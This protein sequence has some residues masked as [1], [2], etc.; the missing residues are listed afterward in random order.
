MN[1]SIK[2]MF[3]VFLNFLHNNNFSH[4][5]L[6]AIFEAVKKTNLHISPN[7]HG[8]HHPHQGHHHVQ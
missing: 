8:V 6:I 7:H 5:Y 3:F 2:N 4:N 1:F